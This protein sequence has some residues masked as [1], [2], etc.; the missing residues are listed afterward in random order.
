MSHKIICLGWWRTQWEAWW[1]I[2][3]SDTWFDTIKSSIFWTNSMSNLPLTSF[4]GLMLNWL[5]HLVFITLRI[6]FVLVKI[7]QWRQ[8]IVYCISC[9]FAKASFASHLYP[10]MGITFN[11]VFEIFP[12][13]ND[14]CGEDKLCRCWSFGILKNNLYFIF[15]VI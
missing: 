5:E 9:N 2:C 6:S 3:K 1:S 14:K 11:C 7:L 15:V 4:A 10:C 8:E 13:R 12:F